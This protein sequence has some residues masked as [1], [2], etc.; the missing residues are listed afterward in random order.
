MSKIS[1]QDLMDERD[2]LR[3]K[4]SVVELMIQTYSEDAKPIIDLDYQEV[5]AGELAATLF[6]DEASDDFPRKGKWLEQI[7]YLLKQKERFLSNTELA[8]FL[9]HYHP[10][11]TL[12]HLKRRVSV[13]ISAAYKQRKVKGLA[14]YS[15]NNT[16]K[17]TVW[18]FNEWMRADGKIM[19]KHQ[20]YEGFSRTI[21]ISPDS[22]FTG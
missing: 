7:L 13:V 2:D 11:L 4:L 6:S 9:M 21:K 19:E 17:N 18:G 20:P 3:R 15:R 22:T 12:H 8:Q 16:S 5:V 14:K 1:I 10:D